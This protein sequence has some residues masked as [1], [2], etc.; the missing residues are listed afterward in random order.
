MF[1]LY[2]YIHIYVKINVDVHMD[3][4]IYIYDFPDL[5]IYSTGQVHATAEMIYSR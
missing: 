1:N 5:H 3:L 4:H 2:L